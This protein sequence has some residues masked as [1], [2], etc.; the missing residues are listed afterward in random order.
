MRIANKT[1]FRGVQNEIVLAL[2]IAAPIWE[3]VT[4]VELVITSMVDGDH[5]LNSLHYVGYAVD[6]R[7]NTVVDSQLVDYALREIRSAL[8]TE[9]DLVNEATHIHLEFQPKAGLNK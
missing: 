6:W 5:K 3:K 7:K 2:I 4:G 8:T 1:Q 9:F